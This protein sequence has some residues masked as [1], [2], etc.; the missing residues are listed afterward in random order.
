MSQFSF[1][2]WVLLKA[3]L[4]I[5]LFGFIFTS[6]EDFV[7]KPVYFWVCWSGILLFLVGLVLGIVFSV[8]GRTRSKRDAHAW[9]NSAG[10]DAERSRRHRMVAGMGAAGALAAAGVALGDDDG[11]SFHFGPTVNVDGTPM[12]DNG[13]IDVMGKTYGDSGDHSFGHDFGG[14]AGSSSIGGSD[15]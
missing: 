6:S 15:W 7:G 2:P 9:V 11:H 1:N 12:M 4:F 3:G 14:S 8:T 10:D 13:V 5:F